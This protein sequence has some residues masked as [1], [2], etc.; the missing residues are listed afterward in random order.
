LYRQPNPDPSAVRAAGGRCWSP[1]AGDAVVGGDVDA[2]LARSR[3]R[4]MAFS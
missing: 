1:A 2:P 3:L 4:R